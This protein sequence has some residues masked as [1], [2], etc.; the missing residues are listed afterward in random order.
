VAFRS[1]VKSTHKIKDFAGTK[2][3]GGFFVRY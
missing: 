2:E 1:S 3:R